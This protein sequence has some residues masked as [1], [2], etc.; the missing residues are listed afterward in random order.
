VGSLDNPDEVGDCAGQ[1]NFRFKRTVDNEVDIHSNHHHHLD[2]DHNATAMRTTGTRE[3]DYQGP[4][5]HRDGDGQWGA[6]SSG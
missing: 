6:D 5:Q 3:E 2:Y 4:G 1:D